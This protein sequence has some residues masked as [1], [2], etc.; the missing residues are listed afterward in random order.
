MS[1]KSTAAK[2][3][4][5]TVLAILFAYSL[6]DPKTGEQAGLSILME[7]DGT[8]VWRDLIVDFNREYPGPP[9]RLIEGPPATNTREDL[10][11]TSFLS[12]DASY[13][14]VYCD[15]IW[16]AKFAAAGWLR[17]L[18]DRLT[19]SD[20]LDFLPA[21]LEAGSY[22]NKLYRM[23]AFTDAGV[24]YYRKDLV[25]KP[26]ETFAELFEVAAVNLLERVPVP[27]VRPVLVVDAVNRLPSPTGEVDLNPPAAHVEHPVPLVATVDAAPYDGKFLVPE[28][29]ARRLAVRVGAGFVPL[30]VVRQ[31]EA[32]LRVVLEIGHRSPHEREG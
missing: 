12:G 26:P 17:D 2:I 30:R 10:Y 29:V 19:V 11:A 7:P 28:R 16:V 6:R 27:L 1:L 25:E 20:R 8:G 3:F 18:T 5:W 13:D 4:L 21:E 15:S 24:L 31:E 32:P 9:V 14:I 23:P 22:R